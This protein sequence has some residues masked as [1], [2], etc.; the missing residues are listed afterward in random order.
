M[1]DGTAAEIAL[2]GHYNLSVISPFTNYKTADFEIMGIPVKHDTTEPFGFLVKS[3]SSKL[4]YLSDTCYT[5]YNVCGLT[6]L[7]IECNYIK[8]VI[9]KNLALGEINVDLRNRIVKTHFSLENVLEFLKLTDKSRLEEIHLLH[10]SRGNTDEKRCLSEVQ[11]IAGC[12]VKI[13]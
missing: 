3:K 1:S 10:M 4:L 13:A 2:H 12:I 9:D 11:K 5:Q 7:M 6:H 8:D